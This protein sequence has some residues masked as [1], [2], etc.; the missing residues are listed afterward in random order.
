MLM[1]P[2]RTDS[3]IRRPA[4]PTRFALLAASLCALA[5]GAGCEVFQ[6]QNLADLEAQNR[7]LSEKNHAQLTEM[8]NL[9]AHARKLE[10]Q[11]IDAEQTLARLDLQLGSDRRRLASL[12]APGAPSSSL[13]G[14]V[15]GHTV[16]AGGTDRLLAL[17]RRYPSLHYD[18]AT[19][20]AK[21]KTDILFDEG[22][23]DLTS[24]AQNALRELARMVQAP[25]GQ[26]LRVLVVGHTDD[27]PSRGFGRDAASGDW[28][29]STARGIAV[30]DFLRRAGVPQ[31]R[32][33]VAGF[34]QHQP[35]VAATS[36]QRQRNRRVEIFLADAATPIVGWTETIPTL[37]WNPRR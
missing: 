10:N 7:E 12:Y 24:E 9:K 5:S 21:F 2:V 11:V 4:L 31:E 34:A 13:P 20:I 6:G 8:E 1:V 23:A 3:N 35:L 27:P 37:Y 25:Q 36:A 18:E 29:L 17:A 15:R 28:Q 14:Q 30:V 33:G 26:E 19:G 16:S 32:L 22:K